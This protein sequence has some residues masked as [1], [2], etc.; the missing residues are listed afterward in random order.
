MS[1][2]GDRDRLPVAPTVHFFM[3][4][5]RVDAGTETGID[6]LFAAG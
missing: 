1:Q 2:A 5:V 4:G 3:G 6:G